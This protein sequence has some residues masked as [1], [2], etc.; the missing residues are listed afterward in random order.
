MALSLTMP[1][2][3]TT[4]ATEEVLAEANLMVVGEA[5]EA[6]TSSPPLEGEVTLCL[7][8]GWWRRREHGAARWQWRILGR[9]TLRPRPHME[10]A[11]WRGG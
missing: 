11:R 5:T 7:N 1:R 2:T 10:R 8:L 4:D 3:A 6:S 9:V